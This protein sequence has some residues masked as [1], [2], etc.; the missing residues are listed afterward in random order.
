MA[1]RKR[2][3]LKKTTGS[4]D[5]TTRFRLRE[6][7]KRI[8]EEFLK[9]NWVGQG[10]NKNIT[11]LHITKNDDDDTFTSTTNQK[12]TLRQPS[13]VGKSIQSEG[14]RASRMEAL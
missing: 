10:K 8:A 4:G 11:L 13:A 2:K 12:Q 7:L 9:D 14:E 3:S 5:G 6:Q 1:N